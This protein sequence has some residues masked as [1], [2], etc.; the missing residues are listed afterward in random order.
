MFVYL[1][2]PGIL[3]TKE[4]RLY[5]CLAMCKLLYFRP[6]TVPAACWILVYSSNPLYRYSV[7]NCMVYGVWCMVYGVW[8]MVY[9]VWYVV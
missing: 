4:G 7:Q 6:A 5:V 8:C 1:N 3:E 9:G 2:C